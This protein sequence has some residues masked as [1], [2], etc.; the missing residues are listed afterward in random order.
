MCIYLKFIFLY[1]YVRV[2]PQGLE[3]VPGVFISRMV[4]GGLAESTG[5]KLHIQNRG[6]ESL[7]LSV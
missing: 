3:K 5:V 6:T 2:A 1:I 4:P 7:I